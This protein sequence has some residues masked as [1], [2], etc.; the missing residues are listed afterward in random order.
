VEVLEF[1]SS[2]PILVLLLCGFKNYAI[3]SSALP[4]ESFLIVNLIEQ[5]YLLVVGGPVM[6]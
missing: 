3:I 5:G 1:R 6:F 4:A 2:S